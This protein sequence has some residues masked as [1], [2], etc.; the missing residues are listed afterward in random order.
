MTLCYAQPV[1]PKC[2]YNVRDLLILVALITIFVVVSRIID[3]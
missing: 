1:E 2:R 3:D